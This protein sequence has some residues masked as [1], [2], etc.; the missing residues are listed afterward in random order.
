[1]N[2]HEFWEIIRDIALPHIGRLIFNII[3]FTLFGILISIFLLIFYGKK[4][5]L[6]RKNKIYTTII[7]IIYIPGIVIVCIIFGLQFGLARGVYKIVKKENQHIVD[8][9]YHATFDQFFIN[10]TEKEAFLTD[11]KSIAEIAQKSNSEFSNSLLH[12]LREQTSNAT[13]NSVSAYLVKKYNQEVYSA[14]LYGLCYAADIKF[15]EKLSYS[16]FNNLLDVLRKTNNQKIEKSIKFALGHKLQSI[17]YKQYKS[18][19][20]PIIGIWILLLCIPLIEFFIYKTW[21]DKQP[22]KKDFDNSLN[23]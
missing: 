18:I 15:D 17:F 22:Q 14:I 8:G 13:L 19:V 3:I 20:I 6:Y 7:R 21:F 10:N 5:I 12:G 16:D 23:T 2:W 4:K 11:L 9:I 1:M